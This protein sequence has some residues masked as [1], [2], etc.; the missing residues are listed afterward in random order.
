MQPFT[1]VRIGRSSDPWPIALELKAQSSRSELKRVIWV[2][3]KVGERSGCFSGRWLRCGSHLTWGLH[4]GARG[5][6][7]LFTKGAKRPGL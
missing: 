5:K 6:G 4:P 7:S 2:R 1:E 3:Y